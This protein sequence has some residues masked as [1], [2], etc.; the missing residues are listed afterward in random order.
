MKPPLSR[1]DA[2]KW[3]ALGPVVVGGTMN[4]IAQP[5]QAA[6][7]K[8]QFKYVDKSTHKGQT[9]ANCKLFKAPHACTLVHGTIQPGGW[10]IAWSKK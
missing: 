2:L 10:C 1:G 5:A 3:L 7:N 4:A 6:D 9:C 8:A